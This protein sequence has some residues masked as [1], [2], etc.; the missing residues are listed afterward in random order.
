MELGIAGKRVLVTGATKGIGRVIAET[1]V[2]EGASVSICA[3]T[4]SDVADAVASLSESGKVVGLAVDTADGD[5]VRAWVAWSAEQLGG[6][7]GYIHG[8]SA[9]PARTLEGWSDNFA[10]DLM[11]L[12]HGADAATPYLVQSTNASLITLGTTATAEHFARG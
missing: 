8:T 1:L 3:R 6:I 5:A 7:D 9:K 10:V 2:A 11:A 4:A 12:V